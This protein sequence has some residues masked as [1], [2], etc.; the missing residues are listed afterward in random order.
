M[1]A[2]A[3]RATAGVI[4]VV[5]LVLLAVGL[6]LGYGGISKGGIRCG[7]AFSPSDHDARVAELTGAIE[8]DSYGGDYTAKGYAG[9]CADATSSRKTIA[10]ALTIPGAAL[11]LGGGLWFVREVMQPEKEP[12]ASA[13]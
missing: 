12:A 8:A 7:S 9:D 6:L 2:S 4:A 10:L 3:R 11:V 1:N 13:A 5:G